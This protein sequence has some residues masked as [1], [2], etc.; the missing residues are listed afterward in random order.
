MQRFKLF[1][2][3]LCILMVFSPLFGFSGQLPVTQSKEPI[4]N[5]F[6]Q[7]TDTSAPDQLDDNS[8][9][10]DPTVRK[11][12]ANGDD[13]PKQDSTSHSGNMTPS[14][15]SIGVNPSSLDLTANISLG[16]LSLGTSTGFQLDLSYNQGKPSLYGSPNNWSYSIPYINNGLLSYNGAQFEIDRDW[17]DQE[18][19]K[20]GLR[21][22]NNPGIK[23]SDLGGQIDLPSYMSDSRQYRYKL[24][25]KDGGVYYFDVTGK[26]LAISDRFNNYILF[27]YED[28]MRGP[29]D[30]RLISI[31]DSLG[32]ELQVNYGSQTI[33]YSLSS[34]LGEI[35]NKVDYGPQGVTVYTDSMGNATTLAYMSDPNNSS[36]SLISEVKDASGLETNITYANMPYTKSSGGSGYL[37]VVS[38]LYKKDTITNKDLVA[39]YTFGQSTSGHNYTGYP[40]YPMVANTGS[41]LMDSNNDDYRYDVTTTVTSNDNSFVKRSTISYNYLSLPTESISYADDG[42]TPRSKEETQY[43]IDHD[44]HA[45]SGNFTLPIEKDSYIYSSGRYVATTK[46]IMDYDEKGNATDVEVYDLTDGGNRLVSKLVSSF[47]N[48]YSLST[49]QE[50]TIY[51]PNG[52]SQRYVTE[53][54]LSSDGKNIQSS[55]LWYQPLG[56]SSAVA[57]RGVDY[58]YDS[59]GFLTSQ[60]TYWLSGAAIHGGVQSSTLNYSYNFG[61]D[62]WSITKKDDLGNTSKQVFDLSTSKL[63]SSEG[64]DGSVSTNS[65]DKLGRLVEHVSPSGLKTKAS[66]DDKNHS[67]TLISPT[68][69]SKEDYDASGHVINQYASINP[70]SSSLVQTSHT[71]YDGFGNAVSSTDVLG[72]KSTVSYDN[73][74]R[75]LKSTDPLGNTTEV[76]YDDANFTSRVYVN[77]I[78]TKESIADVFGHVI[79]D[80]SY[81]SSTNKTYPVDYN[82]VHKYE[83]DGEGRVIKSSIYAGN[84]LLYTSQAEYDGSGLVPSV[85]QQRGG[86]TVQILNNYD[87]FGNVLDATK[88][89]KY[90]SG[91]SYTINSEVKSYDAIGRLVSSKNAL[92][93]VTKYS[94]DARNRTATVTYPSGRVVTSILDEDGRA[95]ETIYKQ[96]SNTKTISYDYDSLGRLTT[97]SDGND[98]QSVSY[99]GNTGY[100]NKNTYAD[101]KSSSVSYDEY[102]RT[103]SYT[104]YAGDTESYNYDSYGRLA[105][106]NNLVG[107][108]K[109]NYG[110]DLN[111][112]KGSLLSVVSPNYSLQSS[113]DAMGRIIEVERKGKNAK[114]ISKQFNTYDNYNNIVETKLSSDLDTSIVSNY[115]VSY[116]YDDL[117]HLIQSIQSDSKGQIET[118]YEY[119]GND[120]LLSKV[121]DSY[122]VKH[123]N[124]YKYN[125]D[126]QLLEINQDNTIYKPSYDIDGNMQSDGMGHTYSFDETGMLSKA[127]G[128]SYAYYADGLRKSREGENKDIFYYDGSGQ[129]E[130]IDDDQVGLRGFIRDG[131]SVLASYKATGNGIDNY[132]FSNDNHGSTNL[133]LS[134]DQDVEGK[135]RYNDYGKVQTETTDSK[136]NRQVLLGTD[137]SNSFGYNGEYKDPE[138]DL[139]Y[140]KAR[141]Y[142]P[143]LHSFISRD[144][145]DMWNHYSYA[146]GN[147]V[148]F[149]DPNGHMPKWL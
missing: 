15:V 36:S 75:P 16:A 85:T 114:V 49:S 89:V 34:T 142:D 78:L 110:T 69:V 121:I 48:K 108:F 65:Y 132:Y 137:A 144:S 18:G 81:P 117:N 73:L 113:P 139:I 103:K 134:S 111:G 46:Q 64:V 135:V 71:D 5:V 123:S 70:N 14:F 119:D 41:P 10:S 133:L 19:Y 53:N 4:N 102:G 105:S 79:E 30:T 120:N 99:I 96:G 141:D 45:R 68:G 37:S 116:R 42:S 143:N 87:L 104:G 56:E 51:A 21:Y 146:G 101:G 26:I 7:S 17:T 35:V 11:L 107:E 124:S 148:M 80:T 47:D 52:E 27:N 93:A 29:S 28:Q 23:F 74:G 62:T 86:S 12:N 50:S 13:N 77:S 55:K 39:E 115:I 149:V 1:S 60:K 20:S 25:L 122:G 95:S 43:H 130:A 72:N 125:A 32:K 106:K 88:I 38:K 91:K 57:Y 129:V 136:I 33:S 2:Y 109:Y 82:I 84:T 90:G 145:Y 138:T 3:P 6:N 63:L 44:Y 61:G 59:K 131:G 100:A 67:S 97:I 8:S 98:I 140:L 76:S 118:D 147:P 31:V 94:Y 58:G 24:E 92:G 128:V 127:N 112:V 9:N 22:M 83:R 54:S 66:Y 40:N 126:D